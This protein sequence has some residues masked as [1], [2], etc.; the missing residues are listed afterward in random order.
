M[1]V[2]FTSN[3]TRATELPWSANYRNGAGKALLSRLPFRP[4]MARA[5]LEGSG[6][7]EFS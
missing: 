7:E 6:Q 2:S 3:E 1:A 4:A 5:A